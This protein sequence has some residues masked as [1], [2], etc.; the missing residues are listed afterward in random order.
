MFARP[1]N[2]D[3]SLEQ[4]DAGQDLELLVRSFGPGNELANRLVEQVSAWD[5]A[6]RPSNEGLRISAYPDDV[7]IAAS[8][9]EYVI[10]KRWTRLVLAW[11]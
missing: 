6:G 9:E 1:P 5:V 7:D 3:F 2:Q 8:T 10:P 11:D 4:P